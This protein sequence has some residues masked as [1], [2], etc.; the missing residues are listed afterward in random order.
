[1]SD[2]PLPEPT[3]RLAAIIYALLILLIVVSGAL[4]L[5]SRPQPVQI[6]IVPPPPTGTPAPSATPPPITVYI[7]GA[8]AAADQLLTLPAGSRVQ[9]ALAAAGGAL[10][11]ADLARVNLAE[12]LRD[13]DQVHV[14]E[15]SRPVLLATAN[16]AGI[17][18]INS[19]TAEELATLPGVG[20]E[21]AERIIRY[22]EANGPFADLEALDAVE[23]IGPG[24][25]EDIQSWVVFD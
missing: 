7:T 15:I 1:M 21:L 14:P 8:V 17:V 12:R 19:A 20:P 22:R 11:A 2:N 23:G 10:P 4:L 9:D 6:R 24:V 5:S 13:G 16:D 3:P 25:L 18:P